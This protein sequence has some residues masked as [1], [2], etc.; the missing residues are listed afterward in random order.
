MLSSRKNKESS[1]SVTKKSFDPKA[2]EIKWL[3][4]L[5]VEKH[6]PNAGRLAGTGSNHMKISSAA[7]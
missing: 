1:V 2:R 6:E 7:L 4:A 3:T 5:D